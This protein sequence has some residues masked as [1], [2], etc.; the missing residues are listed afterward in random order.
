MSVS[1]ETKEAILNEFINIKEVLTD[2]VILTRETAPAGYAALWKV[3]VK[4]PT[5]YLDSDEDKTPKSINEIFFKVGIKD[6]FPVGKPDVFYPVEKHH[7]GVNTF[8]DGRQCID[9][10]IYDPIHAGRNSTLLNTV[11]KT[12]KD[13]I[14]DPSVMRFDSMANSDISTWQ[15][16]RVNNHSFP[17]VPLSHVLRFNNA[18]EYSGVVPELPAQNIRKN[19]NPPELP[20]QNSGRN[21]NP[22]ALPTR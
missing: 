3:N 13:I 22:P 17:T 6:N 20:R 2:N 9:D 4:A 5:Y 19:S 11:V 8:R 7:A 1:E 15:K 21:T 10:W 12:I 18:R 14:Y 16:E